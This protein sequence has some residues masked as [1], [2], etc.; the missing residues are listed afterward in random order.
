MMEKKDGGEVEKQKEN[1][2]TWQGCVT[3]KVRRGTRNQVWSLIGDFLNLD[4]LHPMISICKLV[5]GVPGQPGCVRYCSDVPPTDDDVAGEA[6]SNLWVKERLLS[7][8]PIGQSLSYEIT[9]NNMGFTR[10][11]ATLKVVGG[12]GGDDG[13][14]D[15][16]SLEWRFEADPVVGFSEE[17]L[18][19]IL[20]NGLNGMAAK[21]EDALHARF[22]IP[23]EF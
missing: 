4:K 22:I 8:D 14:E 3:A 1:K 15:G 23:C 21:V 11:M 7:I 18:V 5:E 10:Y 6:P 20:Q 19:S 12:G 9:E 2:E 17:G 16:C 13:D